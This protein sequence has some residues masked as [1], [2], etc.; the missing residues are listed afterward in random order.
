MFACIRF[1]GLAA[2]DGRVIAAQSRE[3]GSRAR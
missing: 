2:V 1:V 3:H